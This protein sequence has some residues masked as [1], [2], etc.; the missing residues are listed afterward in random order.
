[1]KECQ[2]T[3]K[4]MYRGCVKKNSLGILVCCCFIFPI[5]RIFLVE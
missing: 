1:M 3:I 4:E 2:M 5:L